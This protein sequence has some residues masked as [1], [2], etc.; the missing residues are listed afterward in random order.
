MSLQK[1]QAELKAPKGQKN[2]FGGYRFRS[3]ED[4]LEAAKPVLA[5]Y[6]CSVVLSD[7]IVEISGRWYVKATA[8]LYSEDMGQIAIAT[9][10]AREAEQ[11]KGMDVAQITGAASS[12]AR[13]YACNGLFAIDDTKDPDSSDNR[14]NSENQTGKRPRGNEEKTITTGQER[15]LNDLIKKSG[16]DTKKFLSW[17]GV[18]TMRDIKAKDYDRAVVELNKKIGGKINEDNK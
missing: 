17:L 11:K 4:I 5:K 12:Y 15:Q 7:D 9:A 10:Y 2:D 13:K 14:G 8:T 6:L 18:K 16:A 1:I 3:A